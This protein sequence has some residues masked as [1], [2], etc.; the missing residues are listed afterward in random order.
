MGLA[1]GVLF[2]LA[3][4]GAPARSVAAP[5]YNMLLAGRL[6]AI[7]PG[8]GGV[9]FGGGRPGSAGGPHQSGRVAGSAAVA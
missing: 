8:H 7:D 2:L 9:G 6:I 4:G 3:T 5:L 1:V